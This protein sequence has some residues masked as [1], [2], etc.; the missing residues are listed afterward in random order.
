MLTKAFTKFLKDHSFYKDRNGDMRS[1]YSLRHTY[2][3]EML[4]EGVSL[5]L[6]AKQVGNS[7]SVL[8][9]FYNQANVSASAYTFSGQKSDDDYF[10]KRNMSKVD[11]QKKIKELK[12]LLED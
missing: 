7:T 1:L 6:V 2:A 12:A 8:D 5:E 9:K 4:E 10:A 11:I 3:T